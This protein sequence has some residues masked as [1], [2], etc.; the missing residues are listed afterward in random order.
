MHSGARAVEQI[1]REMHPEYNWV[2]RVA[3]PNPGT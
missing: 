2:V 1:L 3:A